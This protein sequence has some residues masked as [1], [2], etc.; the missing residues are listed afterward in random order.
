MSKKPYKIKIKNPESF[1]L[2]KVLDQVEKRHKI[3][4]ERKS[5]K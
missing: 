2:D 3:S 5:S 1:I 4:K